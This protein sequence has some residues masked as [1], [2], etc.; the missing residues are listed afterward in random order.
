V[1]P[2]SNEGGLPFV[3]S[4]AALIVK[5]SAYELLEPSDHGPAQFEHTRF[6]ANDDRELKLVIYTPVS[7]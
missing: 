7:A 5:Q 4:L 6:Q 2:D 3:D 1:P